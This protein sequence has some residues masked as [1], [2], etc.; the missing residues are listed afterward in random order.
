MP[1]TWARSGTRAGRQWNSRATSIRCRPPSSCRCPA[2]FDYQ[3]AIE[4]QDVVEWHVNFADPHLFVA[5]AAGLFAQDEMQ[6]AEHPGLAA[7][8]QALAAADVETRTDGPEGPRRC[9]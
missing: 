4:G 8:K 3:P 7:L 9:S 5:Y 1:S 2:F 6:V